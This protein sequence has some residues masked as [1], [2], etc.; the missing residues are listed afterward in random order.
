LQRTLS[1]IKL[2]V[3]SQNT[4]SRKIHVHKLSSLT[5]EGAFEG[6]PEQMLPAATRT[7]EVPS[8]EVRAGKVTD[9]VAVMQNPATRFKPS[10]V[11]PVDRSSPFDLANEANGAA[12]VQ[13]MLAAHCNITHAALDPILIAHSRTSNM[14]N[15]CSQKNYGSHKLL[16]E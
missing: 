5:A 8:P 13:A 3:P 9:A 2:K 14:P 15:C 11:G 6:L 10:A 7:G 12:R 16:L 1:S 4:P